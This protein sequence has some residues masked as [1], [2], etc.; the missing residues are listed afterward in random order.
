MEH[1]IVF[2]S[3]KR[4]IH[5][6]WTFLLSKLN[7]TPFRCTSAWPAT[8]L[9]TEQFIEASRFISPTSMIRPSLQIDG[10]SARGGV[11]ELLL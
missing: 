7:C 10:R 4:Y 9:G 6:T 11:A 2:S 8:L 3:L 1:R 5:K